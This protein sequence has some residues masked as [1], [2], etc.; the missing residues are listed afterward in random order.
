MDIV[1]MEISFTGGF[2]LLQFVRSRALE[3]TFRKANGSWIFVKRKVWWPMLTNLY[4]EVNVELCGSHCVIALCAKCRPP[5][6]GMFIVPK[7]VVVK[8]H[9]HDTALNL[10]TWS[11]VHT[12]FRK[13][14]R[15][16]YSEGLLTWKWK[17]I[18]N[19]ESEIKFVYPKIEI[20]GCAYL[21]IMT[22]LPFYDKQTLG[23][24][25][26]SPR[27]FVQPTQCFSTPILGSCRTISCSCLALTK[28]IYWVALDTML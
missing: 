15:V 25:K 23:G 10:G 1:A 11:G 12:F 2:N 8:F 3:G 20:C 16:C 28:H 18:H 6:T 4:V 13:Q 22:L 27:T 24:G 21:C 14:K 19:F 7:G 26:I 17:R 5:L 9:L